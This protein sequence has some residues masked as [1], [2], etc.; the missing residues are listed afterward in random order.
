MSR[1]ETGFSLLELVVVLVVMSTLMAIA[2]PRLSDFVLG[3]RLDGSA[4]QTR[5]FLEYARVV[6]LGEGSEVRV[7]IEPGWQQMQ[8]L[9]RSGP[10]GQFVPAGVPG[11]R[12]R[13]REGVRIS[14]VRLAGEAA[15][16]GSEVLVAVSPLFVEQRLEIELTGARGDRRRLVQQAGSGQVVIGG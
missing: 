5:A 16:Q 11:S 4:R 9:V 12:Y 2:A 1:S 10:D 13:L 6:A 3:L 8:L 7:R 14:T 15:S